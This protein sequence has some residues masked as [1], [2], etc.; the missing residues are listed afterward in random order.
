[1]AEQRRGTVTVK[2]G[3][4]L[5]YIEAG[6]GRPLVMIPGWS[7]SAAEFK[8]Q[9]DDF[10]QDRRVIALDM[11]G[12]G[13]SSKPDHGYRISR[14]A[15]DLH[16]ALAALDLA[17]VD[18]LGHSMGCSVIWSHL[19]LFG[20]ERL[21]RLLLIDQAPA[22]TGRPHWSEEERLDCG[23]LMPSATEL[24]GFCDAVRAAGD[25]E[26]E[27]DLLAG[28]FTGA[29]PRDELLWI[30]RENL[31]FPRTHAADLLFHHCLLDWRDA[32][33]RI[34]RPTLVVGGA[35]SI[36]PPRSQEWIAEQISGAELRIFAEDEGGSHF[37]FY[38]NPQAFN[39]LVRD[40]LG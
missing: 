38:E 17:E 28:M 8:H 4:R 11:R 9:I 6:S 18:V 7:Q 12:H 25:E 29:M 37:M 14:L 19:T 1:M 5:S 26:A 27:A 32:I 24:Y 21:G 10:A 31:K 2:D 39:A 33:R 35:K 36:F 15:C 20:V 22:V 13:E 16:E 40:F 3:T 23:C 30:A 34:D